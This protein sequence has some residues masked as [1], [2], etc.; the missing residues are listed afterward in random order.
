MTRRFIDREI[1]VILIQI[2]N[3]CIA[4]QINLIQLV[5]GF[6]DWET[7]HTNLDEFWM[8]II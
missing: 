8:N 6:E 7:P 5:Q 4:S 1:P 3:A 2:L